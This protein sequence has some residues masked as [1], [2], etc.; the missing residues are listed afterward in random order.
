MLCMALYTCE[1]PFKHAYACYTQ[2]EQLK[3]KWTCLIIHNDA[4]KITP[5]WALS[6]FPLETT[7]LGTNIYFVH[8]HLKNYGKHV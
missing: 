3:L 2:C 5:K 4:V 7:V 1:W 8:L 6:A